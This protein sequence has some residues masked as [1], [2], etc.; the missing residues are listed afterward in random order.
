MRSGTFIGAN[1]TES[2]SVSGQEYMQG[3]DPVFQAQTASGEAYHSDSRIL[4]LNIH[5]VTVAKVAEPGQPSAG[6]R[7]IPL[8]N[9]VP[10]QA[11]Q[12]TLTSSR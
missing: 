12:N 5:E 3:V 1:L 10:A 9:A 7:I 4:L 11:F 6:I 2:S 8:P